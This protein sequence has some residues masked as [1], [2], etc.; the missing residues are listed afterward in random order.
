L[1][2]EDA[3]ELVRKI[4]GALDYAHEQGIVHRDVKPSNVL[5]SSGE[6]LIADFG[7]ALAVSQANDGRRTETGLSLGTPHYM[8]PEQ[9]AGDRSLDPRSDIYALGCVLQELLTGEPPFSGANAQAVLARILTTRPTPVTSLR[10][11]VPPHIESAIAKSLEKLP[12][13]R[14]K[15]AKDFRKALG[16][17]DFRHT[18]VERTMGSTAVPTQTRIVREGVKTPIVAAIGGAALVVGLIGGV[19]TFGGGADPAEPASLTLDTRGWELDSFHPIRVSPDGRHFVTVGESADSSSEGSHILIRRIDESDFRSLVGPGELGFPTFSPDGTRVAFVDG[20]DDAIRVVPV[21]GGQPNTRFTSESG[22]PSELAWGDDDFIYYWNDDV[23]RI[24]ATGGAVEVLLEGAG[25]AYEPTPLPGGRAILVTDSRSDRSAIRLFELG[26]DSSRILLPEA[27][28]ATWVEAGYLVYAH[29]EGG[30][31]A[32]PFDLD[33]LELTGSPTPVRDGISVRSNVAHYAVSRGG[34]LVYSEGRSQLGFGGSLSTLIERD[35]ETGVE[36]TIPLEPRVVRGVEYAPDGDQVAFGAGQPGETG[37][38]N[39]QLYTYD[40][41]LNLTP[42]PWTERG[43]NSDPSWSPDGTR[44]AFVEYTGSYPR[45]LI[46]DVTS[47][48]P[49][50]PAPTSGDDAPGFSPT[51]ASDTTLVYNQR[52]DLWMTQV[53]EGAVPRSYLESEWFVTEAQVSPAG[54]RV[55]YTNR[56]QYDETEVIA[57]SF[58]VTGEPSRIS[59]GPGTDPRWHPDGGSILYFGPG[60]SADGETVAQLSRA[61]VSADPVFRVDSTVVVIDDISL[62]DWDLHP[63]GTRIILARRADSDEEDPEDDEPETPE[64]HIVVLNWFEEMHERLGN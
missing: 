6:P 13:D 62:R 23:A 41:R 57:R 48:A 33:R 52:T 22:E 53:D 24:P 35:L 20:D 61:Y 56:T 16:D 50:R 25:W 38:D 31:Q 37:T 36:T 55:V 64:R 32:V 19:L 46:R 60:E 14:F 34:T 8:S 1:P 18:V 44:I 40:L 10:P 7:I 29:P 39:I 49:A 15:T 45:V 51:W 2:V 27:S 58:P 30:L 9:A 42:K 5:L 12:A 4:A 47:E 43:E 3:V 63:D 26:A 21:A 59:F 28:R 11:T 17:V 54:D